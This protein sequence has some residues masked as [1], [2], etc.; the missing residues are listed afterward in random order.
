MILFP[1]WIGCSGENQKEKANGAAVEV[2][3]AQGHLIALEKPAE[4]IVCLYEPGLDA[5]YMLQAEHR[6]VGL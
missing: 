6:I 2:T 4:R 1:I 3:D 5:L